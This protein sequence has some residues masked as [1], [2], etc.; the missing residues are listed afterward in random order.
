[1]D[2]KTVGLIAKLRHFFL[3]IHLAKYLPC[4]NLALFILRFDSLGAGVKNKKYIK[5]KNTSKN[6]ILKN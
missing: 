4:V 3:N 2:S 6:L 5:K 1:M